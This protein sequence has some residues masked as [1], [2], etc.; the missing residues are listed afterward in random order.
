MSMSMTPAT[1]V[2]ATTAPTDRSMPPERMTTVMATAR[3]IVGA[4]LTSRL[5]I[6]PRWN[7][8]P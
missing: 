1:D 7:T 8:R 5:D 3:M 2:N 6:V 4:K